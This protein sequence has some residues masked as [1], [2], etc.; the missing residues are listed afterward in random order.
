MQIAKLVT[1][2]IMVTLCGSLTQARGLSAE[3]Q[4]NRFAKDSI[5]QFNRHQKIETNLWEQTRKQV[6]KKWR[7]G[8][9]PGQKV[10]VQYFNHDSTRIKVDYKIGKV[11]VES[12]TSDSGAFGLDTT[13]ANI[14]KALSSVI[15]KN[16]ASMNSLLSTDLIQGSSKNSDTVA[17]DLSK[18]VEFVGAEVGGDG[19][20]RRLYR[21]TFK[22]VPDYIK[23]LAKKYKPTVDR[24]AHK[25]GLDPA[26]VLGIIRQESAFNPRARSWVGAIGLMQV[27][28]KYAGR[29][30]FE[31]VL[32]KNE[33]PP[34]AFLYNPK[35][36]IMVGVTYLQI[37]R[38]KY[39]GKI[40]NR[41][42]RRYLMI[43]AYN[44]SAARLLKDI[45]RGELPIRAPASEVFN[46]LERITPDETKT[47]LRKV[48]EYSTEFRGSQ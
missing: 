37:L 34:D 30:V 26:L 1:A 35:N 24:W 10:F 15:S 48:T 13:R 17:A 32:K 43:C 19:R 29:E 23:R 14:S 21:V 39:F 25:Y 46:K 2:S 11:T 5:A 38:D 45:D 28:P 47:Y 3:T 6:M 9:M 4:W 12:L 16:S 18:N 27:Y 41:K 42:K 33:I 31:T 20:S 22:L 36:N 8:A 44:W 7:D 40:K